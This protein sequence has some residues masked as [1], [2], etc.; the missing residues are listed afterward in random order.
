M[1][2]AGW[3]ALAA[4]VASLIKEWLNIVKLSKGFERLDGSLNGELARAREQASQRAL[5]D[6]VAAYAR[7]HASATE[8]GR[9]TAAA[10][11]T[12]RELIAAD[13]AKATLLLSSAPATGSPGSSSSS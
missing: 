12:A 3:L 13:A 9:I 7:G 8:T 5:T 11:S 6:E 10:V 4:I 2:E 1:S